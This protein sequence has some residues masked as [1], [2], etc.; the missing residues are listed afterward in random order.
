MAWFAWRAGQTM[1]LDQFN[2]LTY[3]EFLSWHKLAYQ[4]LTE[5]YRITNPGKAADT[6]CYGIELGVSVLARLPIS[7]FYALAG[8]YPELQRF[9]DQSDFQA[10]FIQNNVSWSSFFSAWWYSYENLVWSGSES[11]QHNPVV[12]CRIQPSN[13]SPAELSLLLETARLNP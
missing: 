8:I 11:N 9:I 12:Y 4:Q 10:G 3:Y 5:Q 2:G 13:P 1:D 7:G 6:P